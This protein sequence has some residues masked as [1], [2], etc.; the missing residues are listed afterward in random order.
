M[1][2]VE[3][4][5][6]RR[7]AAAG[8]VLPVPGP[9]A[10]A[11]LEGALLGG[12]ERA[13]GGGRA[14]DDQPAPRAERHALRRQVAT[15]LLVRQ[16]ER[17]LRS[18]RIRFKVVSGSVKDRSKL[19]SKSFQGRSRWFRIVTRSFKPIFKVVSKSSQGGL[20]AVSRSFQGRLVVIKVVPRSLQGRVEAFPIAVSRLFSRS[21][22][23]RFN[24]GICCAQGRFK[25]SHAVLSRSFP[26]LGKSPEESI[27]GRLSNGYLLLRESGSE[28]TLQVRSSVLPFIMAIGSLMGVL[29]VTTLVP[30]VPVNNVARIPF[31]FHLVA[32]LSFSD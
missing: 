15:A 5:L 13:R 11:L 31:F 9:P 1:Q 4:S 27:Q 12:P 24:A 22:Q 26:V 29:T 2:R 21:L 32:T 10:A 3:A 7:F 18:P 8:P 20:Q 30:N 25:I 6:V 17:F 16:L 23:G 28:C 14:H 19:V